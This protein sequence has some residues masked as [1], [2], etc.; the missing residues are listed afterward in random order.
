MDGDPT[1]VDLVSRA[2][3]GDQ[4]AWN[5]LVE[6]YAPLVW[7]VCRR[8]RLAGPEAEDVGQNVWLRLFEHL[9][10]IREPAALP[11]WLAVTTRRE[12]LS[13]LRA[14]QREG[15]TAA[16]EA[17]RSTHRSVPSADEP[18]LLAE[19][20]AALRAALARLPPRCRELLALLAHDPPLTYVE[21]GVRM[22]MPTGGL[23]PRRARCLGKLRRSPP[24]AAMIDAGTGTVEGGEGH[25]EPMV[26]R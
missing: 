14:R 18:V 13:V 22:G 8:Y 7:S 12:C 25:A 2:R 9:A 4:S 21:I 15:L 3:A 11:G 5:E 19:R 20:N 6:R 10:G 24:L 26:E 17:H 16:A 23:G 1:V